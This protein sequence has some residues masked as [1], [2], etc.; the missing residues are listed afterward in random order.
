[1]PIDYTGVNPCGYEYVLT[2]LRIKRDKEEEKEDN[3]DIV[4]LGSKRSDYI[5]TD[6]KYLQISSGSKI[7]CHTKHY[8]GISRIT[9]KFE[10]H[11]NF[12]CK[13]VVANE[14]NGVDEIKSVSLNLDIVIKK[15]SLLYDRTDPTYVRGYPKKEKFREFKDPLTLF[16]KIK[17]FFK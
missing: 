14:D 16:E 11:T 6:K 12:I 10:E 17:N 8:K 4:I 5:E 7:E 15:N 2:E 3:P 9:K 1:M 13:P